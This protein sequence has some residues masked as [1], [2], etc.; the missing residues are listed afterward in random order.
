MTTIAVVQARMGSSRLP[1]KVLKDVG[2]RPLLALML[3]RLRPVAVDQIV[4]ATSDHSRDD[5]VADLA[6]SAGA[7]VVRGPELDVLARF[8]RALDMHPADTV[9]RLTA[10]CPF[11]DPGLVDEA[12][13]VHRAAG[14][15]Y[16][17]NTLVRTFPDGLDV[18]VIDS[19][20]LCD[21]AEEAADPA[22][23]EHVTPFVQ[24]RPERFRLRAF[25]GPE[26]LGD[27]RWTVDTPADLERVRQI[28]AALADPVH[29]GWRE[30]LA[31][32]GR[33]AAPAPDGLWLR[34][35]LAGDDDVL[36]R[37]DPEST[38]HRVLV[39]HHL[40]DPSVRTWVL[41]SGGLPIGWSQVAVSGGTGRLR[42]WSTD[43]SGPALRRLTEQALQA[44]RQVRTLVVEDISAERK[45]VG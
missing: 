25:R 9:V 27:E 43:G 16:T 34:P 11:V 5:P 36:D 30:V 18:E 4:V 10:D 7:A 15:D 28:L 38:G 20:A 31:V 8:A 32:A 6:T 24:R 3:A 2:G 19:R 21:A 35:A 42:Y 13:T 14:A 45:K 39:T 26:L 17:S 44:D 1:G 33:R 23:R 22:E 29:A 40:A 37:V 41:E 12:V